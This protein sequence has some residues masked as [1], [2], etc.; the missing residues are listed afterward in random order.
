[1]LRYN[2]SAMFE[3]GNKLKGYIQKESKEQGIHTNYGYNYYFSRYFLNMLYNNTSKFILKGSYS[4]FANLKTINRPLTDIDIVTF[5]N[6]SVGT[7]LVEETLNTKSDINFRILNQFKTTNSTINYKVL[8]SFDDKEGRISIDLK[9]EEALD[10][11]TKELPKLFSKDIPFDTQ[12]ISIEEHLAS[13]IY[14]VLLHLKLNKELNKQFRRFK[15][16]FDIHFI[17]GRYDI[18][19]DLTLELLKHKIKEDKY[20]NI[21]D[22]YFPYIDDDFI[23]NNQNIW[24]EDQKKLGF[25]DNSTFK[26]SLDSYN[27]FIHKK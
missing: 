20:L 25:L 18:D 9:K 15:D 21:Y 26:E 4:S 12:T 3:T 16:L 5:H 23:K 27:E 24:D 1:M 13:K 11:S 8:A 19:F 6:L 22:L 10:I 17:L 7:E 14:V 2:E